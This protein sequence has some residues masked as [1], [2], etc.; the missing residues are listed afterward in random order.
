MKCKI[1]YEQL[2]NGIC[3]HKELYPIFPLEWSGIVCLVVLISLANIT[4]IGGGSIFMPVLYIFFKFNV[5][6]ISPIN[7]FLTLISA[8][9]RFGIAS[10]KSHPIYI[11]RP[12]VHYDTILVV[13]PLL[14]A[15]SKVGTYVRRR[16]T[17]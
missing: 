8:L 13:S 17:K 1:F 14:I 4:G 7:A 10:M 15:S 11:H 12:L 6:Q 5:S 16:A 2:L 9:I 3:V